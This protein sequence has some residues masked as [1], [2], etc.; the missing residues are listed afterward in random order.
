M[1]LI[2]SYNGRE[3]NVLFE[4][5][6]LVFKYSSDVFLISEKS[7]SNWFFQII[8]ISS[9]EFPIFNILLLIRSFEISSKLKVLFPDEI[10]KKYLTA[11]R[12]FWPPWGIK[13]PPMKAISAIENNLSTQPIS[14]IKLIFF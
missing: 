9:E 3:S 2:I 7:I 11:S 6:I 5:P 4:D 8:L 12:K 1:I 10:G 14:S 13:V